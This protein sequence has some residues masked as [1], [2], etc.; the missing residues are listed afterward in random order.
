MAGSKISLETEEKAPL[1]VVY[2]E[3]DLATAVVR[4]LKKQHLRVLHLEA[5]TSALSVLEK[6]AYIFF[7]AA[8][9][10]PLVNAKLQ[11]QDA[12][13][14]AA[15]HQAKVI[16]VLDNAEGFYEKAFIQEKWPVSVVEV[17][18][19]FDGPAGSLTETAATKIIRLGFAAHSHSREVILG[20]HK[21]MPPRTGLPEKNLSAQDVFDR[22]NRFQKKKPFPARRAFFAGLV[23]FLVLG[24]I[25]PLVF[26]GVTS[27]AA[28]Y[29]LDKA[30]GYLLIGQFK[31]AEASAGRA[32]KDLELD[33]KIISYFP[34][35]EYYDLLTLAEAGADVLV[36][37]ARL[38][39]P[40]QLLAN[41]LLDGSQNLTS[42]SPLIHNELGPINDNL[43]LIEA[44]AK[45]LKLF[46]AYTKEIPRIRSLLT[47]ADTFLQAWPAM[48]PEIGR[49][50]YLVIFQNSA[51]LRPTGG[52]IG[53]YAIVRFKD[54][55]LLDWK[56]DDIYTADGQL[57]GTI[58]PPDEILHFLG[59]PGWFMRDGNWA[60]DFPL[61]ARRLEWF[62]EKETGQIVDGVMAVNLGAAQRFLE[63]TGPL[64]LDDF[65][66]TVSAQDFF[67]K[68]E[69]S[70]EINF[71][72]GSTQKRDFLGAV[73][74]AILEKVTADNNKNYPAMAKAL[75]S[76]L[77]EKDIL[78]YFNSPEVQKAAEAAGWAGSINCLNNCLMLVEANLGANKANYFVK[79]SLRVD[80]VISKGGDV[81]NTVTV[82]YRN[83]SPSDTWP[84]GKYRNYLR[85]LVPAGSKLL[86]FDIGDGRQAVVSRVLTADELAKVSPDEVFVFQT[87]ESGYVSFGALAEIPIES[88][89]TVVFRYRLPKKL[90]FADAKTGYTFTFLKQPGTGADLLD[91]SLEFPAFLR[92]NAPLVNE[93]RL[94]YNSDITTDRRFEVQFQ[95]RL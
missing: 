39:P 86:A 6:P 72:A 33:K 66:Q 58:D 85:F 28:V 46:P 74:K 24:I 73:A 4:A 48:V 70:A 31:L 76:A 37:V 22:L 77:E 62:L 93:Q 13:G 64:A 54:G 32:K 59:Q 29:R 18:G 81:D 15:A 94:V 45:N 82:R 91:F 35:G 60:A 41:S 51:E 56:I 8:G 61:T 14:S 65:N 12:V 1:A 43:G 7:F 47:K 49:K 11:F 16:L 57:H 90:S 34:L 92:P 10:T 55:K 9:K 88:E 67:Q 26:I 79:R 52:F 21:T 68:A 2:N 30:R 87:Q 63:A 80:S 20:R 17:R 44:Q 69:F 78:L 53:S 27:L 83:D 3:S 42:L 36:R 71:F 75:V 5:D 95:T 19:D 25:S 84:A 40:A 50:T 23:T 38:G 89:Q